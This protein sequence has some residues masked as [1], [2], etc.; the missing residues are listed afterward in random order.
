MIFRKN[1]I[2]KRTLK[3]NNWR[4]KLQI[5]LTVRL[6]GQLKHKVQMKFSRSQPGIMHLWERRMKM[7]LNQQGKLTLIQANCVNSIW[8]RTVTKEIN[9]S[10][11]MPRRIILASICMVLVDVKKETTVSF[12]TKFYMASRFF[13]LS[14]IM[15]TSWC[16]LDKKL[17]EQ[18]L[19]HFW[20]NICKK[21]QKMSAR[22]Q[23][24]KM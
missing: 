17:V 2:Q 4:I 12:P 3:Y 10:F 14:K 22:L 13:C 6:L 24:Q 8:Q 9:A 21:K 18:T 5:I 11:R 7:L 19:I 23:F 16:K 20:T 1:V 15:K